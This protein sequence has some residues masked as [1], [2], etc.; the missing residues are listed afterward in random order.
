MRG[1]SVKKEKERP[2]ELFDSPANQI[3]SLVVG[4]ENAGCQ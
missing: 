1:G 3:K 4:R 2:I